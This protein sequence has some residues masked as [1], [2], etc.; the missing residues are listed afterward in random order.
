M[1]EMSAVVGY[2]GGAAG[3]PA[4]KVCYYRGPEGSGGHSLG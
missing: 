2:A 4:G 1:D 3:A